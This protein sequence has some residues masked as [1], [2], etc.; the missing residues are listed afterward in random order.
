MIP[1]TPAVTIH[2]N[3]HPRNILLWNVMDIFP[4]VFP[5]VTFTGKNPPQKIYSLGSKR[6]Q[7]MTDVGVSENAV[8][9]FP[10][11]HKMCAMNFVGHDR[12]DFLCCQPTIQEYSRKWPHVAPCGP[13]LSNK[14]LLMELNICVCLSL[15]GHR[16]LQ[17][18]TL[19]DKFGAHWPAIVQFL[20]SLDE[21][22]CC[23]LFESWGWAWW[24]GFILNL[25]F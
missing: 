23:G 21:C 12:S 8:L 3:N 17:Q 7:L 10:T 4:S 6:T 16:Y 20:F 24:C 15:Q 25:Y 14:L 1:R 9:W 2:S 18:E 13:I 5:A 19:F 11:R 22:V